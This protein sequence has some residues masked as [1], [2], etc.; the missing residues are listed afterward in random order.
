MRAS[1]SEF[2]AGNRGTKTR[3]D[4][5][6]ARTAATVADLFLRPRQLRRARDRARLAVEADAS[7]EVLFERSVGL[8]RQRP[9][10]NRGDRP[11][12]ARLTAVGRRGVAREREV[13]RAR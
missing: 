12:A 13:K 4:A 1:I 6:V 5:C 8:Q 2:A 9:D 3:D 7:P 11:G 10:R